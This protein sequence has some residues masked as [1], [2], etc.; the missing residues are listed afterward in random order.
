MSVKSHTFC[1]RSHYPIVWEIP[2]ILVKSWTFGIP[3]NLTQ[4]CFL[5]L[6]KKYLNVHFVL[7]KFHKEV[8]FYQWAHIDVYLMILWK[9]SLI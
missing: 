9:E 1:V 8:F 4:M 7:E 2:F 5:F 6:V 3:E